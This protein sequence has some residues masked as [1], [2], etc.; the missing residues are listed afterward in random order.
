MKTKCSCSIT[1]IASSLFISAD[2]KKL[3]LDTRPYADGKVMPV[4]IT[5]SY[6][7]QF[8]IKA[9]HIVMPVGGQLY[10]HDKYLQQYTLLEE[11]A[12]YK[13]TITKDSL[14]QGNSRFE[15]RMGKPGALVAQHAQ[16][17]KVLM[18]PNPA[19]NEVTINYNNNTMA[20]TTINVTDVAGVTMITKDLGIQQQ[21]SATI[22]LD[23]LAAGIYMVTLTSGGDKEVA[24]LVK[25]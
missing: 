24:R 1:Q 14:S 17:I 21:G 7:Q 9:D 15:L 11:G 12:E 3:S 23:K 4:G 22:D 8:I 5:S 25:E 20:A 10:L 13:F 2:N 6:A 19:T 18:T 16:P